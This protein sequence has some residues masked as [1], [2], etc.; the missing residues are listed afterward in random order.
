MDAL[1]RAQLRA[2]GPGE[3]FFTLITNRRSVGRQR[4]SGNTGSRSSDTHKS[5]SY[6]SPTIVRFPCLLNRLL[7]FHTAGLPGHPEPWLGFI[8]MA[9]PPRGR[10]DFRAPFHQQVDP[11]N[12]LW[13]GQ[14]RSE[15]GE[16]LGAGGGSI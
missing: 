5:P 2:V 14:S 12:G 16:G 4:A 13:W 3:R 15:A 7:L 11:G 10:G 9:G 6:P 1:N 8:L